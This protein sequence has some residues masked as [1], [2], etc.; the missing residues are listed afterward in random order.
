MNAMDRITPFPETV[1]GPVSRGPVHYPTIGWQSWCSVDPVG[2]SAISAPAV[3]STAGR[4]SITI[5]GPEQK[6][7]NNLPVNYE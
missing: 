7:L 6:C 5:E 2:C 1:H 4:Q 3:L